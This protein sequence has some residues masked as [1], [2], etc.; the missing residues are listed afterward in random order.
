MNWLKQNWFKVIIAIALLLG[1]YVAQELFRLAEKQDL[2][3]CLLGVDK[4]VNDG[5]FEGGSINFTRC[6][7]LY[8]RAADSIKFI[9]K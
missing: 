3:N 7:Q 1:I 5:Y 9:Y 2:E 4:R 8:S 6:G